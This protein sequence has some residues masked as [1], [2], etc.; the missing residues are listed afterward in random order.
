MRGRVKAG[1]INYRRKV[2]V[3]WPVYVLP[4]FTTNFELN[5]KCTKELDEHND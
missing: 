3:C 1:S 2:F 4:N 5:C